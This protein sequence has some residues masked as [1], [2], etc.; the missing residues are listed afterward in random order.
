MSQAL[1]LALGKWKWAKTDMQFT[2]GEFPFCDNDRHWSNALM[3]EYID[4]NYR[5]V[6]RPCEMRG[7]AWGEK[8]SS[9]FL[10]LSE[11]H[12]LQSL[13]LFWCFYDSKTPVI[14]VDINSYSLRFPRYVQKSNLISLIFQ[15]RLRMQPDTW[16]QV[17]RIY[18][19]L[20]GH[21]YLK[22]LRTIK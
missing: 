9:F 14:S 15:S 20:L 22:L 4:T 1:L 18:L 12:A 8:D 3:N 7:V 16:K 2:F 17:L 19:G 5:A 21:F 6:Q 11:T 10:K 13:F